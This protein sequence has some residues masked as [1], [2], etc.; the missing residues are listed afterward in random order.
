VSKILQK[1]Y[2]IN[3]QSK[4]IDGAESNVISWKVSGDISVAYALNIYNNADNTLAFSVPKTSSYST[5]Y[6][7][8]SN[9]IANAADYKI[10]IQIWNQSGDTVTSDFVIFTCSSRPVV[11]LDPISVASPSYSFTASYSQAE[12]VSL[13]SWVAYLYNSDRI[14]IAQ[15]PITT[16]TPLQYL[17]SNLQSNVKYYIEFVVT[18]VKGLVGTSGQVSFTPSY[19][20]P[21]VNTTLTATNVDNAGIQIAWQT[22]QIIGHTTGTTSFVNNNEIDVTNGSVIFDSN[23]SISQDF[24]LKLWISNPTNKQDLLILNGE[25]AVLKLQYH[26]LD[27]KFHLYKVANVSSI[28]SSWESEVVTGTNFFVFIQQIGCDC[29]LHAEAIV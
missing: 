16:T 7:L 10:Q 27:N 8:A 9:S 18:S 6:T 29:N 14:K 19:S 28:T 26:W 23:F 4:V 20:Q 17:F 11:T 25:N 2:G 5:S 3:L 13:Q 24:S 21:V 15:S 22:V 12:S 1:P